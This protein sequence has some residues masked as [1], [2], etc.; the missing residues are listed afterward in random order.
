MVSLIAG[1]GGVSEIRTEGGQGSRP[2]GVSVDFGKS[3]DLRTGELTCDWKVRNK[4]PECKLLFPESWPK[5]NERIWGVVKGGTEMY[6]YFGTERNRNI[7]LGIPS[8]V[9]V[10]ARGKWV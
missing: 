9:I 5:K 3:N 8:S 10:K 1:C 2:L 6:Y 4:I 7:S